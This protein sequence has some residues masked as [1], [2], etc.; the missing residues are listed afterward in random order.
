MTTCRKLLLAALIAAASLAALVGSAAARR[1]QLSEQHIRAEWGVAELA[2]FSDAGGTFGIN[3]RLTVEG[4]FH[5][6][7]LSKV[8]GQLIGYI[9]DAFAPTCEAMGE[10]AVLNGIEPVHTGTIAPNLLPWHVRFDSF[11]G[12]LPNITS[13]RIQVI[14]AAILYWNAFSGCLFRSTAE[15]P[16]FARLNIAAGG[17]ITSMQWEETFSFL[18]LTTLY[19][20]CP[21]GA[22]VSKTSTL[23]GAQDNT[24]TKIIV[25]LVQ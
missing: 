6:R 21:A 16:L 12:T 4:S 19:G 23:I 24:A 22:K 9:T 8:C 11:T 2:R 5:S 14:G 3:C 13:I 1:L 17:T 7:T 20:F 25:R 15:K 10:V 18:L